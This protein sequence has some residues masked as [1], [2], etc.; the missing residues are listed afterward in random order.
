MRPILAQ[1]SNEVS[2][3]DV[4]VPLTFRTP[5]RAERKKALTN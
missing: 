5:I 2:P 3:I 4:H 1:T